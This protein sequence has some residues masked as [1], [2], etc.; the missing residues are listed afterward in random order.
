MI[1]QSGRQVSQEDRIGLSGT[2]D[3]SV[4]KT[5][6]S[7]RKTGAV[8]KTGQF[9]QEDGEISQE[10]RTAQS[11]TGQFSQED[12]TVQSERWR[13]QSGKVVFQSKAVGS[14]RAG[15]RQQCQDTSVPQSVV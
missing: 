14:E 8:R 11:E 1:G 9:S 12:R 10:D 6:R 7:V 2:Q 5:D 4:R 3:S 13:D 15:S